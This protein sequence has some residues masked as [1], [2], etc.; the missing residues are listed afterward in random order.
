M[1]Q[2]QIDR[3]ENSFLKER[4]SSLEQQVDLLTQKIATVQR[5]HAVL[6]ATKVKIDKEQSSKHREYS[7][8]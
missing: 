2:L 4:V 6:I 7:I 5:Q 3:L 1:S 8:V